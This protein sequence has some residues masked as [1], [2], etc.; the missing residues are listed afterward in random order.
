MIHG[1]GIC[2]G[3]QRGDAI[4]SRVLAKLAPPLWMDWVHGHMRDDRYVP[5]AYSLQPGAMQQ[6]ID[7]AKEQPGKFFLLGCEPNLQ[8]TYIDPG[9]AAQSVRRWVAEVGGE[10][11]VPGIVSWAGWQ[12]WMDVYLRENGPIPTAYHIHPYSQFANP[13]VI[14][15]RA[16]AEERGVTR[17]VIASEAAA[18]WNDAAAN[19]DYMTGLAKMIYDGRLAAAFWYSAPGDYWHLW[20]ATDLMDWDATMLTPLGEHYLSLQEGAPNWPG[21]PEPEPEPAS[22][23]TTWLPSVVRDE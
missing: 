6:Y 10:F 22:G 16:W 18:P 23:R 5:C 20:P 11:A 13:Q 1:L 15:F 4:A 17:P 3:W 19:M 12:D 7:A 2:V 8:D 14:E 9:L 21:L